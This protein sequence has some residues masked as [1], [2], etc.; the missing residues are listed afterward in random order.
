MFILNQDVFHGKYDITM[1][2]FF[3]N[4]QYN[5]YV[6]GVI[7]LANFSQVSAKL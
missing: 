3:M 7:L 2:I 5:V 6:Y 1:I 4:Y